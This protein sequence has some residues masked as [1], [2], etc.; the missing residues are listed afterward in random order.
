MKTVVIDPGHGG[1][2]SGAVGNGMLEKSINLSVGLKVRDKLAS[3]VNV[4]MTR[5]TDVFVE[6]E[7][8]CNIANNSGAVL[9]VSIHHDAGGNG[10]AS[11]YEVYHSIHED[12]G[13]DL[14][15]QIAAQ[16]ASIGQKSHGEG[17]KTREGC[18]GDY[19][20]VIRETKIPANLSEFGFIDSPDSQHFNTDAKQDTEATAIAKG[21]LSHLSIAYPEPIAPPVSP[22]NT[23][24][25][26]Q[27][28]ATTTSEIVKTG[29]YFIRSAPSTTASVIGT[30]K[31]EENYDT[32]VVSGNWRKITVNGKTGYV[33]PTAW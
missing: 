5:T 32:Q 29:T 11:G 17:I 16:F 25:A 12:A 33:G 7:E 13:H 24:S 15:N 22:A 2:D 19:Y 28:K 4:V 26:P 21:I 20:C 30:V 31:G 9:F 6:L 1:K 10:T 18:S 23:Q 14:A 27:P 3:V 8:R